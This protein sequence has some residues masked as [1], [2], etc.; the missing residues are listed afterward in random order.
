MDGGHRRVPD[1]SHRGFE[2][3]MLNKTNRTGSVEYTT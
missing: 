3:N 2:L 1:L